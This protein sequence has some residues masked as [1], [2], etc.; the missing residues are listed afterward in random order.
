V[1][2]WL[3][4]GGVHGPHLFHDVKKTIE[5]VQHAFAM[6]GRQFQARQPGDARNVGRG[7]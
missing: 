6:G 7:Q 4:A 2:Q 5:L 3:H 1:C